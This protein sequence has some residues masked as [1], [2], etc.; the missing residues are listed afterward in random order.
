MKKNWIALV[1]VFVVILVV[2]AAVS[3][4]DAAPSGVVRVGSWD[5]GDSLTPFNDAIA[6]FEAAN[7]EI[8]IQLESV[9]QDYGTKLLAQF[10]SGDAP[11]IF[12][13]GDGNTAQ[14]QSL[15]AVENL[16]PFIDGA[17]G[18]DRAELY[19][20]VAAFGVVAGNTYYL[21]KDYSPLV[22]FYNKDLFDA[23]GVEY[24]TADWTWD[25][26]V[27]AAQK[28]TADGSGNDATSPDFDP[29]NIQRW[30]VQIPNSWGDTVWPRGILPI[31][32]ANGG[33]LI[34]EDG[35][36]T[37]GFMNSDA[38][39][40]AIQKYVDL[41][42]TYHVAPT[43]TDVASF[44]G[45]DLFATQQVAMMWTGRWPLDGYL[46]GDSALTFNFGTTQLPQGAEG[47]AN[48][49]CWAG[50][51]MYSGSENKDAAW[52][53]LKYIGVGDGAAEFA[54]YALTDVVRI[55]EAQGLDTDPYNASII[56]DLEFARPIPESY[57]PFWLD[58]GEKFFKQE[59]E[60]VLEGDVEVR[61]AMDL[62]ASEADACLA[63]KAAAGA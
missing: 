58:C 11:D 17:S 44:S 5:S 62:A 25:D 33:S 22:M 37:T 10:A 30:G 28:L 55:V 19:P 63:E 35:S 9:P 3:A 21:T 49:L 2:A 48:A 52:E 18:F 32:S 36:A 53:F 51:A 15:G 4:Q 29:A 7:P 34:A 57:S 12:Q 6:S 45:V 56:A 40:D 13:V 60:T 61:A 31:I 47:R 14:F 46:N 41:F 26:F 24:P 1:G 38:T 23:A 27:A 43:K 59:L 8:D 54:E 39:V 42:E 50:F 20:G 16:D